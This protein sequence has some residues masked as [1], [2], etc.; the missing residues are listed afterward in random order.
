MAIF[1]ALTEGFQV[2]T[3]WLVLFNRAPSVHAHKP[4]IVKFRQELAKWTGVDGLLDERGG[5]QRGGTRGVV[6]EGWYMKK[7][8]ALRW[9][10]RMK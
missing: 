4:F 9:M 10:W 2:E 6:H 7:L 8:S 1:T 5:E 3:L